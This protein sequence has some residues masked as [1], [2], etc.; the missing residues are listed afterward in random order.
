MFLSLFRAGADRSPWGDFW[1]EP[2]SRSTGSGMRVSP[3]TALS[4]TAV[5]ACVRVRAESF[6]LLPFRMYRRG[7]DGQRKAVTDHWLYRLMAKRPNRWQ[8]PFEFREMLQ[9]HLDLRGNAFCQI[10]DDGA[11][12]IA[13][14]LPMHPDRITVEMVDG[15]D[16]R[17]RYTR[18]DGSRQVFRRDQVW[19]LRGLS[20]DGVVGF[21]PIELARE[22]IGEALQ[23][24][25]YS[26]RFFANNATPPIWIK[27]PGK[28]A[29][30]ATRESVRETL[31]AGQ[32][33]MNR[34]KLMVL[35]QG[36]ELQ[37]VSVNLKD[38]QFL[39]ARQMKV[40]EIARLFRVPPHKIGDLSKATFSNIE[41]QSIE[42]WQDAMQPTAERWEAS[43]ECQLL[44]D[45]SI[46][47]EFDMRAQMR[48]DSAARA[49]YLHN[50]VLDGIL[51]RN[52]AREIEGFDRIEGLDEPLVP[53][54]E[55]ELSD[56]DPNGE[57]GAGETLPDATPPANDEDAAAQQNRLRA[58]LIG[59]ADRMARRIA[60]GDWPADQ[61]L[62]D[63][64]AL[65]LAD[66]GRLQALA[67]A[68]GWAGAERHIVA[69]HLLGIALK[70]TA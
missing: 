60:A 9:G 53:T 43:I 22:S 50:L 27:Y 4:L 10:I 17:Y 13:E 44:G 21:N 39:E 70:G 37:A 57:A 1:F 19:H 15:Q 6:A 24:Q 25:A 36:M 31:Q 54:N 67:Q 8:T 46:D 5:Y 2:V 62:S 11:G 29:D 64:L 30:K 56:P 45:D 26:S 32:T 59:N 55:R 40:P 3:D 42:F 49:Q 65:P 23:Y 48:G 14:L 33:G 66:A 7:I 63:A 34:G 69:T 38:L 16:Y 18:A 51:T 52:E 58:V 47:V 28:M 41:Q 20:G 61:V 35:D 12:G 68:Q